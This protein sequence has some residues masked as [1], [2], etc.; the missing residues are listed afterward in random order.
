[1]HKSPDRILMTVVALNLTDYESQFRRLANNLKNGTKEPSVRDLTLTT[2]GIMMQLARIEWPVINSAIAALQTRSDKD[3]VDDSVALIN[4]SHLL[5]PCNT[6]GVKIIDVSTAEPVDTPPPAIVTT[7]YS[8]G[9]I[10]GI[11]NKAV[12]EP[13]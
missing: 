5:V 9:T 13:L 8:V 7:L 1:M 10:W 3:I 6:D 4:G 2:V 11:I 12:S